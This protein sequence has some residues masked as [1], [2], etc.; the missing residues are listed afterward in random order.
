MIEVLKRY[1]V[2][3]FYF[4]KLDIGIW[5]SARDL[6]ELAL[7]AN[8]CSPPLTLI[9]HLN[10]DWNCILYASFASKLTNEINLNITYLTNPPNSVTLLSI[11][12]PDFHCHS[13]VLFC[14]LVTNALSRAYFMIERSVGLAMF[15]FCRQFKWI[16]IHS[17]QRI[18]WKELK[19]YIFFSLFT[20]NSWT[21]KLV[22]KDERCL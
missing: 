4:V 17:Y 9:H 3:Q 20:E 19:K 13:S 16:M 12:L 8:W 10:C 15:C 1:N 18:L 7:F 5:L 2:W 11:F 14:L 21:R 6:K 22:N